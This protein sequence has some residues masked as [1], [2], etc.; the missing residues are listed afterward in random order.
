MVQNKDIVKSNIESLKTLTS[1]RKSVQELKNL[2][3]DPH[4]KDPNMYK[5]KKIVVNSKRTQ[6]ERYNKALDK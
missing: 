2:L 6:E 1:T 3:N 5:M 4:A